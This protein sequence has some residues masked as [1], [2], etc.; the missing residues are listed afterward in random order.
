MN[1]LGIIA[2][3]KFGDAGDFES[4]ATVSVGGGGAA[5]VEFTSI[6][7]TFTHLQIR[8]I[9][10]TS[11][12]ANLKMTLNSD[13]GSNYSWHQ[14]GGDGS[15]AFA[16]AGATQAFMY[17]GYCAGTASTP[18]ALA[19]DLLD[20]ANT[21]K[22]KTLRTLE[23]N[24]INGAGGYVTLWSGNWRNTNAVTS[25][26]VFPQSGTFSQYTQFALYGIRSA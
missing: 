8:G 21:N 19:I 22:Y 24:D 2:S 10:L 16:G 15:A 11:T 9:A 1:I 3:S 17:V 23:G 18:E 7:A 20:Y 25:I 6:P 13:T 26:K 5:D 4:I 12:G 14:L